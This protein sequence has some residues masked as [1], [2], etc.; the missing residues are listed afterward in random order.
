V[1]VTERPKEDDSLIAC[2]SMLFPECEIQTFS[3]QTESLG[4]APLAPEPTA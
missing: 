4:D 2:L 1:L 3:R